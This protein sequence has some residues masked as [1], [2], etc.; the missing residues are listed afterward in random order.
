MNRNGMPSAEAEADVE[1]TTMIAAVLHGRH[2]LRFERVPVPRATRG[3]LLVE[4]TTVGVCGTDAAEW[5]YGPKLMPL[6]SRHPVTGHLGPL[7]IGHEFAGRVVAV[8]EGVDETLLGRLVASCGAAPCGDCAECTGGR[9]NVCRRYA[10]VGLHR[11]GALARYVTVP[12]ASCVDVGALGVDDVDAALVQPVSIAVHAARRSGVGAGDVAV[13][14]G[15]GGVGAFLIHVL[16]SRGVRVVAVDLAADRLRVARELGAETTVV[17]GTDDTAAA[18]VATWAARIPVFFEV[19]GTPRGV[20][21]ALEVVPMGTTI[22][23]VGIAKAAF[24][25]DLGRVTVREL[26][27]IGTNAMV[28][29]TD[30]ADAAR[31]VAARAGRWVLVAPAPI[32]AERIVDDALRPIAEGRP[33]AIKT[34]VRPPSG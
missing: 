26:S 12:A 32:A 1:A 30:L 33:P 23:Q 8:G 2:D 14:Q 25:L 6:E 17:G 9:S 34:L 15:V 5:E 19:T 10:A 28:R 27:L 3:E 31:L 24:P 13:V 11:H 22:A 20:A 16:A 29:E 18:L 7:V 21:L 4:V